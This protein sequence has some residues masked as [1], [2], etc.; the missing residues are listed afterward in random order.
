MKTKPKYKNGRA[1]TLHSDGS[2]SYYD[3]GQWVRRAAENISVYDHCFLGSAD[4]AKIDRHAKK[5][6]HQNK[7]LS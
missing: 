5:H 6:A 1:I 2:V 7:L 3:G 4:S